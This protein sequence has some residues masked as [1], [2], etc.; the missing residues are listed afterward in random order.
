MTVWISRNVKIRNGAQRKKRLIPCL[1]IFNGFTQIKM[2]FSAID[3]EK[4]EE[5]GSNINDVTV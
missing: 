4:Y 5:K 3:E 2:L 1:A